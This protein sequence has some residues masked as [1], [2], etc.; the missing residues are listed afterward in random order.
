MYGALCGM[1]KQTLTSHIVVRSAADAV[2]WYSRVLGAEEDK[3]RRVTLPDGRLMSVVLRF[4]N[5]TLHLADEFPEMGVVSP[6]TLGGTYGALVVATDDVDTLWQR[7][8]DAGA[9][10]FQ[11]LQDTFFGDRHGQ[12]IDPFGHRWGLSQHIRDVPHDE[13]ARAAAAAFGQ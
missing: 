12:I 11:P 6:L 3:Q 8:L 10:V 13:I 1:P 5:S 4:G 9:Q 2:A 7:A